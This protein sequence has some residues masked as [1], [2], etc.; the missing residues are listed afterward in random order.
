MSDCRNDPLAK[1]IGQHVTHLLRFRVRSTSKAYRTPNVRWFVGVI[2]LAKLGQRGSTYFSSRGIDKLKLIEH[3][4]ARHLQDL[5]FGT[6]VFIPGIGK[7]RI[8][9]MVVV[10]KCDQFFDCR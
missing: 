10:I 9:G 5:V 1:P 8:V 3:R 4:T 7:V 2:H 6:A